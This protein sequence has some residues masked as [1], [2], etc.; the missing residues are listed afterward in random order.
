MFGDGVPGRRGGRARR[1]SAGDDRTRRVAT[2]AAARGR[3]DRAVAGRASSSARR[4]ARRRRSSAARSSARRARRASS[5][6]G[7]SSGSR[8]RRLRRAPGHADRGRAAR[9]RAATTRRRWPAIVPALSAH[10]GTELPG[11]VERVAASST[12]RAGS[13]PTPRRSR[14]SSASSRTDLLD[15]VCPPGGGLGQGDDGARQPLD[16]DPPARA[17]A[18]V[19]GPARPRPVRPRAA[20]GRDDARAACC[21]SRRT[22]AR[23]RATLDVPARAVPDL[24]RAA[25][26]DPRLRVR[27][28]PVAPAVPRVAARA[29]ADAVRQRRARRSAARR[30]AALGRGAPRRGRRTTSTGWSG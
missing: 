9:R 10:L 21:S 3:D 19:H 5:T 4:S 27:G 20:V 30:C 13:R 1:R 18:R 22:S 15:Q 6:G 16:H 25:R 28:A 2:G 29:P 11:V 14:R 7:R 26:D 24:D 23:R 17:A 8:S 12:G